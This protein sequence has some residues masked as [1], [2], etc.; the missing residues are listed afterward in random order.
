MIKRQH[1]GRGPR[2]S[3]TRPG[4]VSTGPAHL[5]PGEIVI[6]AIYNA[7]QDPKSQ[8]KERPCVFVSR[9][10]GSAWLLPLTSQRYYSN[11]E[12]RIPIA[13]PVGLGLLLQGYLWSPSLT[14]ASVIDVFDHVGYVHRAATEQIAY[15]GLLNQKDFDLFMTASNSGNGHLN[16]VLV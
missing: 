4:W 16:E 8:G 11:G 13:D 6:A 15:L 7:H 1:R 2:R 10:G 14:K 12:L 5:A 9:S 3:S